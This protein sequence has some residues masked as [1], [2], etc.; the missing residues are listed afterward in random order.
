MRSIPVTLCELI[1]NN[2]EELIVILARTIGVLAFIY[3]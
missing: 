2:I 3:V 1:R